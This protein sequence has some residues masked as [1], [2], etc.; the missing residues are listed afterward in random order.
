MT[1]LLLIDS[2]PNV[3]K[4]S[5]GI[6]PSGQI[7]IQGLPDMDEVAKTFWQAMAQKGSELY[8]AIFEEGK[9]S[10]EVAKEVK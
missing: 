10:M 4:W 6:T 9:R 1:Y 7:E 3:E 5:V 8:K 2:S